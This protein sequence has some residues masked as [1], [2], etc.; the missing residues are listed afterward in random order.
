[1]KKL[2][3]IILLLV[4]TGCT[5][6]SEFG[7]SLG[8]PFITTLEPI[9]DTTGV[10]LR[11]KIN[12]LPDQEVIDF[13]FMWNRESFTYKHSLKHVTT[14]ENFELKIQSD[15]RPGKLYN[16]QPYIITEGNIV[17]AGNLVEF[18]PI[19]S[20][21][22]IELI[23]FFP[24]EG[25]FGDT[26]TIVGRNFS[27]ATND[28]NRV[29]F[30]DPKNN[31][32]FLVTALFV[33]FDTIKAPIIQ[34]NLG[35]KLR[36]VDNIIKVNYRNMEVASF[37]ELFYTNKVQ[38]DQVIP[39]VVKRGEQVEL[40]GQGFEN[41]PENNILFIDGVEIPVNSSSFSNCTFT[42]PENVSTG[43]KSILL[44]IFGRSYEFE[45]Q[46]TVVE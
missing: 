37:N 44:T 1:M 22:K 35:P 19:A 25:F 46:L 29:W 5:D 39:N 41:E 36:S 15:L 38:L 28:N 11:A 8:I 18:E 43:Q 9:I 24:K 31:E 7:E 10:V 32:A 40:V 14:L 12:Y 13:G 33:S 6:S 16:Y 4:V 2:A 27:A 21:A 3:S 17:V 23:D 26:V 20:S 34:S 45:Q 42:I 30:I